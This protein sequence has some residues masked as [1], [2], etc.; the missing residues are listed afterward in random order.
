MSILRRQGRRPLLEEKKL[1]CASLIQELPQHLLAREDGEILAI[2]SIVRQQ[3]IRGN[4]GRWRMT[5]HEVISFGN[6]LSMP[7]SI[8]HFTA[9]PT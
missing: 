6:P 2:S 8:V 7:G 9:I 3:R 1:E 5:R 4:D